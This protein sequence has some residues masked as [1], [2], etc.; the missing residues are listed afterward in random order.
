MSLKWKINV[1]HLKKTQLR[2]ASLLVNRQLK[3][4]PTIVTVEKIKKIEKI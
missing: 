1:E 3:L 4:S 2:S